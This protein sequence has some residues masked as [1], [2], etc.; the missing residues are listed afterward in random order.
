MNKKLE[1]TP[2]ITPMETVIVA[3]TGKEA[4]KEKLKELIAEETKMVTGIFQCFETPGS[5][6]TISVRKYPGIEPFKMTMTDGCMYEIPLY[7]ARF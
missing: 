3:K 4:V 6:Q 5:T 7:V 2:S 1:I